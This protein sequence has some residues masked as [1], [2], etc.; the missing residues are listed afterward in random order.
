MNA[1]GQVRYINSTVLYAS[2]GLI[3]AAQLAQV[4]T[5]WFGS[6]NKQVYTLHGAAYLISFALY[7]ASVFNVAGLPSDFRPWLWWATGTATMAMGMYLP[8]WWSV[9][10]LGF[11]PASWFFLR[12]QPIG[13]HGDLGRATLDAV[14][15]VL[16]AAAV[17]TL[18]GMVRTAALEVDRQNDEAA[19]ISAKRAAIDAAE[20]ERQKLDDLVHDQVLTTLILAS[21]AETP[22][23]ERLAA[24]SAEKAISRLQET[25]SDEFRDVQ[26]IS[27]TTFLDSLANS[28]RRGY[29][30][31]SVNLTKDA[32]FAVPINVGIAIADAAVQ[33]MTNSVQHAGKKANREVRLKADRH[34]LKVVVKDDGKGFRVSSIPKNRLGVRNSIRRRVESVGGEVN[35]QTAPRKG[36]TIV[37]TWSPNA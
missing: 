23:S 27:V 10:Y 22:E 36:A 4:Y 17:L 30:G 2:L 16:F 5:F 21:K 34:G 7:P 19:E 8:K 33:A 1:S 3:F 12:V 31:C 14:Y 18:A 37:L 20:L 32:D 26:E 11:V 13:G 6:A 15:I 24:E 29:P 9:V 25:A 28:L 35:I